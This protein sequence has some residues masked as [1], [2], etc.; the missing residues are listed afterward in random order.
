MGA[1]W[2]GYGLEFCTMAG[3][4]LF[5]GNVY[6]AF[7]RAQRRIELPEIRFHDPKHTCAMILLAARV[8][9][10]I[11]SEMLGHASVAITLDIYSHVL[12]DMQQNAATVMGALLTGS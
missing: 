4:P 3:P 2:S 6:R 10:K 9:P 5:G 7:K 11:V 1:A 8:N 12:P